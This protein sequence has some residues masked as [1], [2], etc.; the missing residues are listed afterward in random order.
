MIVRG[1]GQ[2]L[3]DEQGR[4]YLDCVNNVC[5]GDCGCL[6]AL[7]YHVGEYFMHL[8]ISVTESQL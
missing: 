1:E 3:F 2:Y 6:A 4:K 7:H 5:H 8:F